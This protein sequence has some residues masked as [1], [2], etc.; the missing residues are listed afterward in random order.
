MRTVAKPEGVTHDCAKSN[1]CVDAVT[2][3]H[4]LITCVGDK[5]FTSISPSAHAACTAVSALYGQDLYDM[6]LTP[7]VASL[8]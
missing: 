2:W 5:G 3:K 4:A 8:D 7:Y 1:A 6:I